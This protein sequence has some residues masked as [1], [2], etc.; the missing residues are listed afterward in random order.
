MSIL[1]TG[2]NGF[3]GRHLVDRL[4]ADGHEVTR[5]LRP[6]PRP[7]VVARHPCPHMSIP[8]GLEQIRAEHLEPF[9]TVVHLAAVGVSPSTSPQE[10]L[11]SFNAAGTTSLVSASLRANVE[12]IVLAGTWAEYGNALNDTC[13][14]PPWTTVDPVTDYAVSKARGLYF[15]AQQTTASS[16]GL[17]YLRIFNAFGSEQNP[18]ALWPSLRRAAMLNQDFALSTG[19]EIRDFIPVEDV[20]NQFL[21][22]IQTPVRPHW[23]RVQ[24]CGTGYG[25]TVRQFAEGW[26]QSWGAKGTLRFGQLQS[27]RWNPAC[28]IALS[29]SVWDF[30]RDTNTLV[31]PQ[32][33]R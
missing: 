10:S 18:A 28:A 29:E 13:P 5:L 31:L 25:Q 12:H 27:R 21:N 22:C 23:V 8:G 4:I 3:I 2:S 11:E 32:Y 24:N 19:S 15:A 6:N 1:V 17:S 9:S 14:I 26:W 33:L 20:V 30:C 16:V 7:D